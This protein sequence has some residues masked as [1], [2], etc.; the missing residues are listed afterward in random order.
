[1]VVPGYEVIQEI[2]RNDRHVLYRGRRSADQQPVLLK[3]PLHN[4]PGSAELAVLEREFDILRGLNIVG[5]PHVCELLRNNGNCCLALEDRG[6]TLLRTITGARQLSLESFFKL[7]IQLAT[8]LSELHRQEITHQNINPNSILFNSETG[9]VD[10]ADFSLAGRSTG[11]PQTSYPR[12]NLTYASPEQTGRMNRAIDYRTDF[13]SLGVTF[14]E[15]LTGRPPFR[16]EDPLE[17]IHQHIAKTPPSPTEVNPEVPEQISAIVMKLLAKTAEQRYQ[18][19]LGL[20]ADLEICSLEWTKDSRISLFPLGQHDV[21]DRFNIPQALYGREQEVEQLRA[22]FDRVCDGT[23]ALMLVA[24]YSGIGKTSLTQEL[25][26]PIVRERGYFISGKFDQI[27]RGVPFGA[28][29]QAFRGLVQQLLTES[30]ERLGMWRDRLSETLGAN[31]G[32]LAEVIPEIELIIGK[33]PTPLVLGPTEALNRFQL[34]FRNFVQALARQEHPLAIFLDD[35]QWADSATLSL[36]QPLLT[37][38]NIQ[39]LFLMGAYRDNEVD[40][41]HPLVRTIGALE[42]TGVALHRVALGPLQFDDLTRFVRDA[43]RGDLPDVAPL[44]QLVLE[45]TN[46]NPFFVIQFLKTLKQEGFLKFDYERQ[47]WRYD[48]EDIAGAAMTDN[49]ID[50][51]TRKIQRLSSKTQ[52]AITLASCIGNPFDQHTLAVVS[53]QSPEAAGD[54]LKEA[55]SEGLILPIADCGLGVWGFFV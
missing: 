28:L 15:L 52:R 1:M 39:Y 16:S 36:L 23:P 17:L 10:L 35:L 11:E 12:H 38:P 6:G 42:S 18:S 45:K 4:S 48:I 5:V 25:Y 26:K 33:Q 51:M 29:I 21:S 32:V 50:L 34:V 30:E 19:A 47:R 41:A 31:G 24:G 55:I 2:A 9:E 8:I 37:S 54:D 27:V 7:A 43:L 44:A 3:T 40:A 20:K 14:Y 46:G 49:V 13:Y 22:A 53:E